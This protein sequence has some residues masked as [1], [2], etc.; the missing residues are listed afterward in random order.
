MKLTCPFCGRVI[1]SVAGNACEP[2][3]YWVQCTNRRCSAQGP[4]RRT[5]EAA[6]KAFAKAP[7]ALS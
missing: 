4:M 3:W 6:R 1:Q 5:I 2:K 7:G